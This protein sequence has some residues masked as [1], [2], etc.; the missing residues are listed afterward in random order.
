MQHSVVSY[1]SRNR[2]QARELKPCADRMKIRVFMAQH[3]II[4]SGDIWDEA[5]RS[6]LG[7]GRELALLATRDSLNSDRVTPSGPPHWCFNGTS[8][9]WYVA[10]TSKICLSVYG[11]TKLMSGTRTKRTREG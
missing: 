4:H 9:R 5:V 1:S 2:E 11:T 3:E 8:H 10:V 7:G 6:A